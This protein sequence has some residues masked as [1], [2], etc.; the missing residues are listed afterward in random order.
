MIANNKLEKVHGF[1]SG[2][3]L[4]FSDGRA[5]IIGSGGKRKYEKVHNLY[6]IF[7]YLSRQN[8]F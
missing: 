4:T 7:I 2:S 5:A 1:E 8:Y 6:K 3:R